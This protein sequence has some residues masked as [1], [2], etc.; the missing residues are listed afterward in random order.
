[1]SLSAATTVL[2]AACA[3]D[4]TGVFCLQMV[5]DSI[6]V[7]CILTLHF[8]YIVAGEKDTRS[9]SAVSVSPELG[10]SIFR[11]VKDPPKSGRT[12]IRSTILNVLGSRICIRSIHLTIFTLP[13]CEKI[14]TEVQH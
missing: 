8:I 3:V 12:R 7:S 2:Q 5:G 1:M 9:S 6:K 11:E 4:Q 13:D 10:Q 14:V